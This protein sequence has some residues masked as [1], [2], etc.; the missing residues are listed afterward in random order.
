MEYDRINKKIKDKI[1][2]HVVLL[3]TG[4]WLWYDVGIIPYILLECIVGATLCGRPHFYTKQH[5]FEN[6]YDKKEVFI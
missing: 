4:L 2:R 1:L 3:M 6:G 5:L